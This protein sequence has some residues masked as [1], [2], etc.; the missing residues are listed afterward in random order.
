MNQS[1]KSPTCPNCEYLRRSKDQVKF[2]DDGT[3]VCLDCNTLW[4]EISTLQSIPSN[5]VS[6]NQN[7]PKQTVHQAGLGIFST[8]SERNSLTKMAAF[9]SFATI[10]I[11]GLIFFTN[12]TQPNAKKT[13]DLEL[14]NISIENLTNQNRLLWLVS[15]TVANNSNHPIHIPAIEMQVGVKGS[16]G[17]FAWTYNPAL[18]IL[19]AGASFKFRTSMNKP[20]GSADSLV[21]EFKKLKQIAG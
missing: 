12:S 1:I 9:L 4:R 20:V 7:T 18:Q 6:K 16:S 17:Y 15:G 8:H 19:D 11:A 2:N 3:M 5:T 14:A 10:I 13:P 21:L